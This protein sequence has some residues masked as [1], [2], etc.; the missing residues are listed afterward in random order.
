MAELHFQYR[1]K[2]RRIAQHEMGH[3]IASRHFGFRTG[4]V[5]VQVDGLTSGHSGEAAIELNIPTRS[6]EEIDEYL[7]RR[8]II[9]YAGALSEP[10]FTGSPTK[11]IGEEEC[12]EAVRVI[13]DPQSGAATDHAKVRE[14]R[15]LL[16]NIRFPDTA[17]EQL[18]TIQQELDQLDQD[19]WS[20]SI[21]LVDQY[22]STI[23]GLAGNLTAR[24][25]RMREKVTISAAELEAL[26]AVAGIVP[27]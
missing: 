16:R 5:S 13:N 20:R 24:M 22:Y 3:Y 25:T 26:P 18:G 21:A 15:A 27:E 17:P 11:K 7:C 6:V 8:V 19:L 14:L 1:Q 12:K 10:L 23:C 9:L 4:D 2:V